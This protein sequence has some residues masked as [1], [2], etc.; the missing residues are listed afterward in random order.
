M[1]YLL[2][3]ALFGLLFAQFSTIALISITGHIFTRNPA[4]SKALILTLFTIPYNGFLKSIWQLPLPE[5]MQGWGFPSGHTHNLIIFW[6]WLVIESKS[7]FCAFLFLVVAILN[8]YGILY[9]GYHYPI[10]I[11]AAWS[12]AAVSLFIFWI[13]NK[14]INWIDKRPELFGLVLSGLCLFFISQIPENTKF[15]KYAWQAHGA[16]IGWIMGLLMCYSVKKPIIFKDNFSEKILSLITLIA[17]LSFLFVLMKPEK[18]AELNKSYEFIRS[19]MLSF[20]AASWPLWVETIKKYLPI[21][22][23]RR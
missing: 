20:I 5:P 9:Q 7:W 19:F 1:D 15:I 18:T 2:Y 22:K 13:L 4:F 14:N 12:F 6:G 23:S 11:I 8:S 16:L 17:F 10:D 21:T 3:I